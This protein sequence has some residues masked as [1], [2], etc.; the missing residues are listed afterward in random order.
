MTVLWRPISISIVK[1]SKI[2]LIMELVS[3]II[4]NDI[5]IN[6]DNKPRDILLTAGL[7]AI[8]PRGSF[9]LSVTNDGNRFDWNLIVKDNLITDLIIGRDILRKFKA[10][11]D[12]KSHPI[13]K[14]T[15]PISTFESTFLSIYTDRL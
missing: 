8:S 2:S 10:F 6:D 14:L 5:D 12:M 4:S 9:S 11:I 15:T 13:L 7:S 3:L 1:V